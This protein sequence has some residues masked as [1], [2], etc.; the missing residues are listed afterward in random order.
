MMNYKTEEEFQAQLKRT[1][2][3]LN[4]CGIYTIEEAERAFQNIPPIDISYMVTP[5]DF[6]EIYRIRKEMFGH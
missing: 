2:K 6:D 1:W 4:E 3:A 5:L